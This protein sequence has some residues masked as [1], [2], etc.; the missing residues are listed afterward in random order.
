ML[1][2]VRRLQEITNVAYEPKDPEIVQ[3]IKDTLA[4]FLRLLKPSG[5]D[6]EI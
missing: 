5:I 1:R 6:F 2:D 4:S 3:N